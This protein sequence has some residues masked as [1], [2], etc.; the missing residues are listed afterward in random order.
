M[1]M[2]MHSLQPIK[3]GK[4]LSFVDTHGI[5]F[6]SGVLGHIVSNCFLITEAHGRTLI[7]RGRNILF[8]MVY[9][10]RRRGYNHGEG[11][12]GLAY[13]IALYAGMLSST[14]WKGST[15]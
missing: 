1:G 15:C 11:L 10:C 13:A 7:D 2:E 14:C 3:R 8:G 12:A 9:I 5:T 4:S 6:D